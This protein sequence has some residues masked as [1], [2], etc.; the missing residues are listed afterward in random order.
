MATFTTGQVLT[1]AQMNQIGDDSGW[2]TISSFSNSWAAGSIA[3]AYRKV[4][5]RVQMRGR[6]SL[7]TAN[8]TAF[9]LP[10]GYR[11]LTN[12]SL[13]AISSTG[14]INQVS[15]DTSGNVGPLLSVITSLDGLSFYVD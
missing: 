1:A 13:C 11:P 8:A 5:N 15:I 9:A 3:P 4:G 7:G 2:I 14:S 6:V 12:Q 10:S